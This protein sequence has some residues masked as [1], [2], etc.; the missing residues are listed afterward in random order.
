MTPKHLSLALTAAA[1]CFCTNLAMAY[2]HVADRPAQPASKASV[3]G[4]KT[5]AKQSLFKFKPG[6][7]A[8]LVDVNTA[9]KAALQKLPGITDADADKIIANRPY[10]SKAWLVTNKIVDAK[11]Y[12]GIRT[13]IEARQALKASHKKVG[14]SDR[15]A[16]K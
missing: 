6:P 10:G 11:T 14:A 16:K 5:P 3:P 8:K 7:K 12:S 15:P 13:L 4:N 9:N 1:F 2:E